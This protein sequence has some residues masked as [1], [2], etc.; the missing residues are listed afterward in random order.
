MSYIGDFALESTFDTKFTTVSTAGAP[1]TLAGT[2]VI[3]AYVDNNVT[4][5]T[6]GITLTVDFD[7]VT[8]LHNVRVVA[9]AAN[10]YAS[11]GNYQLVI[12]TGTVSGTSVVGYVVAEF[13]IQAR[14]ALRPATANR[15][16]VVDAAGLVDAN[17]VKI[18]PTGS[19]TAQTAGDVVAAVI[20]NAA[21]VDIAADIIAVKADTAAILVDTGTTLDGRIP[22]ALTAD[23]NMKADTLRVGG[24][25]Q[26]AGDLATLITAV[27]DLVDTEVAAIKTDTA[28]IKV[29]TDKFVFTVANQVDANAVAIS[30]D[31]TAAD[32]LE[33]EYDGTGYG[34]VLQRT[35]IA[36]LATQISFT[37][38]A[39]SA[40]NNAYNGCIIVIQ[41]ATTA[42]QKAVGV[43]SAYT[44][45]T[46]TVTLLNDPAVFTMAT[47]DIVTIIADRAL[48]ATVDNRTAD[49]TA[50]GAVGID[51]GNIENPTTAQN[52]SA[53]NIDVDQVVASVSGAVGSVT[54]AVGSVTGLTAATVHSDLDDI[55]AKI[56][57]PVVSLAADIAVIEGQTDDIGVAGAGLTALGD[58]RIANLDATVSSRATPTNITAGT[59]T[60]V[61]NL[62]NAPTAGDL[63]AA[64]KASVNAELVDVI[65]TDTRSEPG[66]AVMPANPTMAEQLDHL[67]FPVRNPMDIDTVSGFKEFKNAAGTVIHKKAISDSAGVYSEALDEV[68]P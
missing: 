7:A 57:T 22:A 20:T 5:L 21:G 23:G 68:G 60:T 48:K 49:V 41:D 16:V 66:A 30:G 63:T 18:G 37:L 61:T 11:G 14:S 65:R 13:S 32:N 28:A 55:Q 26:T 45:A 52:L 59:I 36:T 33:S 46:K 6:A 58:T 64:M 42:A 40:D 39:G 43:I 10:G 31:T 38:T 54:G 1:T 51:W 19:G 67:Y 29:T 47:T 3:S 34:H 62:T 35:T 50:T 9:T 12:T 2:P 15:T 4:Q 25:L 17:A 27:D 8:G 53:T 56:G 24:T 44:G